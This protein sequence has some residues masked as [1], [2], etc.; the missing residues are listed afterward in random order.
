MHNNICWEYTVYVSFG[1]TFPVTW[2]CDVMSIDANTSS[3]I[4]ARIVVDS[5]LSRKFITQIKE[6]NLGSN[7]NEEKR[8]HNAIN[9]AINRHIVPPLDW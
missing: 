1:E 8:N 4:A 3:L 5:S 6:K 2:I 7:D 9:T